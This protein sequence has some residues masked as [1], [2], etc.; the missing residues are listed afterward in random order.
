MKNSAKKE[1][2]EEKEAERDERRDERRNEKRERRR[3]RRRGGKLKL[4]LGHHMTPHD[5]ELTV[6]SSQCSMN[7][8]RLSMVCVISGMLCWERACFKLDTMSSWWAG[9]SSI[10]HDTNAALNNSLGGR[11]QLVVCCILCA[12]FV[13]GGGRGGVGLISIMITWH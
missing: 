5:T 9:R 7:S 4:K 13:V 11:D 10:Q 3:D 1:K 8:A 2:E 12:C 6:A